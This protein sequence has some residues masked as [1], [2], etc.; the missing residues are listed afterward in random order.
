M[1]PRAAAVATACL[2][3]ATLSSFC[4]PV[5]AEKK[6]PASANERNAVAADDAKQ[7]SPPAY[8]AEEVARQKQKSEHNLKTIMFAL[9]DYY[10]EF[11][12]FPPPVLAGKGGKG[13]QHLH[14]W[15]VA[16]LP[17]L[18]RKALYEQYR[19]DEPWDSASNKL[20]LAQMPAVFRAPGADEKS[21]NAACLVL[22]GK[23]R[24]DDNDPPSLQTLFSSKSGISLQK[25]LD[26][27]SNTLAVVE[28][29]S[30]IPWTKPADISYD[31]AAKLPKLGGLYQDGFYVGAADGQIRLI[32]P[33][34]DDVTL[35]ALIS[36]AGG[37]V[38][39]F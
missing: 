25:V 13:G 17:F 2:S 12:V 6:E 28:T 1:R 31:P 21:Q 3:L 39:E 10:D 32:S 27:C 30:E 5:R 15:R 22:V 19:F 18:D 26:G 24:D 7:T 11:G 14:S 35:K 4:L 16:L 9:Y 20:I 29:K 38:A 34:V 8:T 37:E 33:T 36:P 23:M